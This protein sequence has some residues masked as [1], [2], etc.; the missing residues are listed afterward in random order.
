MWG[1]KKKKS[2]NG[3]IDSLIGANTVIH[4]DL[5]FSGGLHIDGQ[6]VGNVIAEEGV[7][8]TLILSSNGHIKG[9]V[10]VGHVV[11]NGSVTGNVFSCESVELASE[12]HVE[13]DVYYTL[14]EMAMGAEVNGNLVHQSKEE[15][16][17]SS[18][19]AKTE[20]DVVES[21]V[22]GYLDEKASN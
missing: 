21:A 7:S 19:Q 1:G 6:V 16:Q 5:K 17:K 20:Q 10:Q 13:G 2:V 4:G 14:L 18:V 8:S 22:M 12:A 11:L 9:D 15:L 3:R